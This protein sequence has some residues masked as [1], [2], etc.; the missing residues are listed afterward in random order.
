[1]MGSSLRNAWQQVHIETIT[2]TTYIHIRYMLMYF[3]VIDI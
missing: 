3:E 1:M 2:L